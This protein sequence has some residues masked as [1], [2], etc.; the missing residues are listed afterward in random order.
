MQE[1]KGFSLIEVMIV[2]AVIGVLSVVAV[3]IYQDYVARGQVH[4]AYAEI[5]SYKALVEE[6]LAKGVY[7]ISNEDLGYTQ[8]NITVMAVGDIATFLADG[9]GALMVTLGGNA[10]SVVAGTGVSIQRSS[11]GSWSCD[12]DESGAGAWKASY[13]PSGCQ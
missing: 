1:V 7:V 6:R 4:R 11:V 12:I 10:S 9:S 13:M 5:S 2:I 3:P 8:S